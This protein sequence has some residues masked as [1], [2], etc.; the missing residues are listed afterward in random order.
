MKEL[1]NIGEIM[2]TKS[3]IDIVA[4][5]ILQPINDGVMNKEEVIVRGK[6][7]VESIN[8]AIKK[9]EITENSTCL[10]AKIEISETGVKYNYNECEKWNEINAKIKPLLDELKKIE[11][12]IK[13]ATKKGQ[14]FTDIE[15][16]ETI[17]PVKKESITS[18]K[19][20]LAK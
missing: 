14:A 20:T 16:G 12:L 17:M 10:G 5:N 15:T 9:I 3:N 7:I 2:P 13:I 11:E 6:F 19:V 1:I 4:Q 8:K 18:Y